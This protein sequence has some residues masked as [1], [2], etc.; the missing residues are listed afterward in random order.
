MNPLLELLAIG[1]YVTVALLLIL[2]GYMCIGCL[3]LVENRET[4]RAIICTRMRPKRSIDTRE[5]EA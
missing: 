3:F 2:L 4:I 1:V 5:N